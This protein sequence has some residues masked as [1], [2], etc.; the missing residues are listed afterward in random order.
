[1]SWLHLR[2]IAFYSSLKRLLL[3]PIANV[4]HIMVIGIALSIPMGLYMMADGADRLTRKTSESNQLNVFLEVSASKETVDVV[5]AK[6]GVIFDGQIEFVDRDAGL[7]RMSQRLGLE[8]L[9][10]NL[11]E[12]PLP[13]L[14]VLTPKSSSSDELHRIASSIEDIESVS[15][16]R[17]DAQWARQLESVIHLARVCALILLLLVIF[18]LSA[19]IFTTI[20][21]QISL[22]KDEIEVTRLVGA[23]RRFIR[24][25]FLYFAFIQGSLSGLFAVILILISLKFGMPYTKSALETLGIVITQPSVPILLSPIA[26]STLLSLASAWLSANKHLKKIDC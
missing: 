18:G 9:T 16:V 13:H 4:L 25:P 26:V 24:R 3:H 2:T 14:L 10:N 12:N 5:T 17:F 8:N 7:T 15:E 23:T 20:R 21:L 22:A 11:D 6:I 1:M 19:T